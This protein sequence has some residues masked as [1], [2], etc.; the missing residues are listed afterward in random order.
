MF[1]DCFGTRE[2]VWCYACGRRMLS[3][4]ILEKG[5]AMKALMKAIGRMLRQMRRAARAMVRTLVMIGDRLVSILVPAPMPAL[6][7]LEPDDIAPAND[8]SPV[9]ECAAIRDLAYAQALG[10]LPTPAQLGAVTQLQVDW[11]ASM[12]AEMSR[13]LLRATDNEIRAHLRG[14]KA[15]RGV[16]WCDATCIDDYTTAIA[17]DRAR[18]ERDARIE[19][20]METGRRPA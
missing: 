17:I 11:I 13:R 20:A 5:H 4:R 1:I 8:N 9:S 3:A 12:D 18:T 7:E 19:A 15:I 2:S 10:R 6:D 16:L 14:T